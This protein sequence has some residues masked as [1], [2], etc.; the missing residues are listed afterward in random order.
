MSQVKRYG[1]VIRAYPNDRVVMRPI[2]FRAEGEWWMKME[3]VFHCE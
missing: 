3:E 2:E 1:M